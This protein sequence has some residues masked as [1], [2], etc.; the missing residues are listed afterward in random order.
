MALENP[1]RAPATPDIELHIEE[2]VLHGFPAGDRHRIAAAVETELARLLAQSGA[3]AL[4]GSSLELDR[5]DAGAFQVEPGTRPHTVGRQAA[6]RLFSQLSR[7]AA[8]VGNGG[9]RHV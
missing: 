7:T 8:P 4:P 9:P 3:A 5:L 1:N 2:L 6:Q